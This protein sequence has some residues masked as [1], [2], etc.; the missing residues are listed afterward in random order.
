[1]HTTARKKLNK[2]AQL[3]RR[4]KKREETKTYFDHMATESSGKRF[5]TVHCLQKSSCASAREFGLMRLGFKR[6]R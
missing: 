2:G 1:M 6:Q 5:L 3:S 4:E